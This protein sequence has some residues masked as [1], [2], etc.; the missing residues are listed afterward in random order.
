VTDPPRDPPDAPPETPPAPDAPAEA[1]P[2][3]APQ[4]AQPGWAPQEPTAGWAPQEPTAGWAPQ[5]LPA[6]EVF[7]DEPAAPPAPSVATSDDL[8]AAVGVAPRART[9]AP[10]AT[11]DEGDDAPSRRGR[12]P[13]I[14]ALA[15]LVGGVIAAFVLV[16]RSNAG[17]F[18]FQCGET[19]ISARRGRTFPP[20]GES[21]LSGAEWKPI[22]IPPGAECRSRETDSNAE[23][24]QWYLEALVEQAQAKLT[25][26]DVTEVDVAQQELEQALLLARDPERRDQRKDV[27][28]LLGDVEYWRGSAQVKEALETLDEAAKRFDAAA[29]KRPRHAGDAAAWA[30]WLREVAGTLRGG[31][32]GTARPPQPATPSDVGL[33]PPKTDVPTGVPLPVEEHPETVVTPPVDAGVPR[34]GVLL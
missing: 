13:L 33:A 12:A 6:A 3:W 8:R 25:A 18:V 7:P 5:E 20:W 31:P 11:D 27:E 28:R 14:A 9:P 2:G 22:A 34:G 17:R 1:P 32:D 4:E 26:K 29:E 15:A 16:G 24:A 23:L 10:L 30:A 19:T 21:R